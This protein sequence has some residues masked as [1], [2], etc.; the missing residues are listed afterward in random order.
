MKNNMANNW[1]NVGRSLPGPRPGA[2]GI[3]AHHVFQVVRVVDPERVLAIS[4]ND[5]SAVRTRLRSTSDVIGWRDVAEEGI[6]THPPLLKQQDDEH[7]AGQ[8]SRAAR[9]PP[10]P[11]PRPA[12]FSSG[13]APS[14]EN[15]ITIAP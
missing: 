11:H 7:D 13:L 15:P 3:K 6:A 9:S 10:V 14:T 8:S 2:L 5:H 12:T 1:L 4:G